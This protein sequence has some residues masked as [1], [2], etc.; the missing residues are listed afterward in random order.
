MNDDEEVMIL[1]K[2]SKKSYESIKNLDVLEANEGI[3]PAIEAFNTFV[4]AVQNGEY[5]NYKEE[6][7]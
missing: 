5:V 2:M 6:K 4:E 3:F 7:R 1:V